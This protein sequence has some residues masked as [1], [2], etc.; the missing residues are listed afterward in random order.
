MA[1]RPIRVYDVDGN[2]CIA[3]VEDPFVPIRKLLWRLYLTYCYGSL[4][5]A[6]LFI[7]GMIASAR[8]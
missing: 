4:I 8:G 3:Y 1:L 7:V 5:L 2:P 6:I